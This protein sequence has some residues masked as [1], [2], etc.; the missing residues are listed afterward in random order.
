MLLTQHRRSSRKRYAPKR[1]E[2]ETFVSGAIDRYQRHYNGRFKEGHYIANKQDAENH[3]HCEINSV[4]NALQQAALGQTEYY[5]DNGTYYPTT[6]VTSP[7]TADSSTTTAVETNLLGGSNVVSGADLGFNI[8]VSNDS[9]DYKIE[10]SN[11][12][13]CI[14]TLDSTGVS[15][16]TSD[17]P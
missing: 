11:A 14:L 6:A 13:G 8:C 4:K 9:A 15:G 17:C 16:K 10:A 2:D 1:Y 3:F 5:T 7:C 12:T